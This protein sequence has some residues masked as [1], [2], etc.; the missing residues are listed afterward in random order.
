V[1]LNRVVFRAGLF[2]SALSIALLTHAADK[3]EQAKPESKTID[4]GSFG[5]FIKGQ[6]VATETFHVQQGATSST[7]KSELKQTAGKD[8]VSQKSELQV[9]SNGELV[10]YDWS[11][12]SGGSLTVL[13]KNEFLIEKVTSPASSK[14][15]EQPFLMPNTSPILDNNFFIHREVL[16]WRYLSADCKPEGPSFKCQKDPAEFG[17]L[18]PQDRSSARVRLELVGDEKV[19]IRGS[20]RNLLRLNLKGES[21][22]WSLWVDARDQFKLIRVAIP[23]D[24]TEVVRD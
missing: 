1:K 11:Q 12:S 9:T 10:L 14:A 5:I 19:S 4:S 15:A 21:F 18:I 2:A 24:D 16:I 22:E 3:K 7:I 13:P 8:A 20:E 17:V 6:R 23:A